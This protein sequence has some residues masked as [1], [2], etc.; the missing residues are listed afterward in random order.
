MKVITEKFEYP[1]MSPEEIINQ[2][3]ALSGDALN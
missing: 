1:N 2:N 3:I